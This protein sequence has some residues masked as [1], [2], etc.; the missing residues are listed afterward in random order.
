ME[1]KKYAQS[2]GGLWKKQSKYG[3]FLT[4]SIEVDG[5]KINIILKENT[6][7]KSDKSPDFFIN[8]NTYKKDGITEAFPNAKVVETKAKQDGF[9]DE[10]EKDSIPFS[11]SF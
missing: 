5:K 6:K 4:G 8:E 1:E 9:V 10:E 2:I 7:K 11:S 3:E